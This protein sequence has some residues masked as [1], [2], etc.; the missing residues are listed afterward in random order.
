MR[1]PGR[2]A[3]GRAELRDEGG[4]V[5]P[6]HGA[7]CEA[8]SWLS[9]SRLWRRE[10]VETGSQGKSADGSGGRGRGRRAPYPSGLLSSRSRLPAIS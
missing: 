10:C 6:G 1:G 5:P 2:R 9:G 8:G 7:G 4:P 3:V